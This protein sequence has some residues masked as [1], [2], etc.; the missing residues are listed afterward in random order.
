MT[1]ADIG[2]VAS[3]GAAGLS[4]TAALFPAAAWAAEV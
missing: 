4:E 2:A 3:S 1:G